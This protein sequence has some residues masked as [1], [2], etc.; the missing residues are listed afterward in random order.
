MLLTNRSLRDEVAS[1]SAIT[2]LVDLVP[3][4]LLL[5]LAAIAA[6]A[7]NA[8]FALA[9]GPGLGL[10]LRF[11][12]GVFLAGGSDGVTIVNNAFVGKIDPVGSPTFVG[13]D[14]YFSGSEQL[15]RIRNVAPNQ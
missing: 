15:R 8:A 3:A 11:L 14:L 6:A 9:N 7:A 12:T 10:P 2:N 1:P 13:N 5:V 4:R